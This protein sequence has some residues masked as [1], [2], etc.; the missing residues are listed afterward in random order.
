M[1][2]KLA[3]S[4]G[5]P[6][7]IGP[8]ICIK[9]FAKEKELD[10]MPVILGDPEV[11]KSRATQLETELNIIEYS[12]KILKPSKNSLIISPIKT[13]EKVKAGMPNPK[14]SSYVIKVLKD[15]I[16]RTHKGEF[17]GLV[18]GPINKK[19]MN[20]GG[21]PFIGHTEI[22][23]QESETKKV[24]MMLVNEKYKVALA[25]THI[26]LKE[27]HEKISKEHLKDCIYILRDDLR[28][29]WCI[30]NPRIKILGLNPHA[31]DGGYIGNEEKEI[32]NPLINELNLQGFNL[33]GPESADTAFIEKNML[34]IDAVLSMY[35]DQ[36]LP[37][38]KTSGFGGI[39]NITLGLPFIR[40][41][42]DHGTAYDIA[43]TGKANEES[44]VKA[45]LLANN[46]NS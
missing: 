29:K 21:I 39:V 2:K 24:V 12:S 28:S 46:I 41:S 13:D 19:V 40:T 37:T 10:Y 23:A 31:G 15:C 3:I 26:P 7:G 9:A 18:T 22:L 14:N 25:T 38:I 6:A 42:V 45:T 27:V 5:D 1:I 8:D 44:L 35:H 4:P 36:G 11:F 17:Q 34:K 43:G 20:D 32:I 16:D 30:K 33:I